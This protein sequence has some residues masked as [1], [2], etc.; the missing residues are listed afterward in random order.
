MRKKKYS[1]I[2][3]MVQMG[4]VSAL[5]EASI[6]LNKL[7]LKEKQALK[8]IEQLRLVKNIKND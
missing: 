4:R 1:Q 2:D 3:H 5:M 8:R 7:I 6:S